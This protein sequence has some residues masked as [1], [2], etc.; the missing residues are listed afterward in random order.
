MTDD[1][2][3]DLKTWATAHAAAGSVQ[4][5]QVLKL[6]A[7][8]DARNRLIFALAERCSGQ[9][10]LLSRKAEVPVDGWG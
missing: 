4:A 7:L 10:E 8:L 5:K 3:A 1:A 9:S 2:L 6:L